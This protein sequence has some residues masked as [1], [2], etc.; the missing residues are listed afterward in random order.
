MQNLFKLLFVPDYY[1]ITIVHTR[2]RAMS[3]LDYLS[4]GPSQIIRAFSNRF[5]LKP[6]RKVAKKSS[7]F[8]SQRANSN[9]G[10][11]LPRSDTAPRHAPYP[12][13]RHV[14]CDHVVPDTVTH[15]TCQVVQASN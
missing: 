1:T 5:L 10:T 15:G 9:W 11:N 4:S 6:R 7:V 14:K 3:I 8:L 2:P 13:A 12:T